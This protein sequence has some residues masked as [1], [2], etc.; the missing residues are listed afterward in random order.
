[1][2]QSLLVFHGAR[3]SRIYSAVTTYPGKTSGGS[4]VSSH[5]VR[6]NRQIT[7]NLSPLTIQCKMKISSKKHFQ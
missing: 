4:A 6:N 7:G 2:S 5:R 1:M 3:R